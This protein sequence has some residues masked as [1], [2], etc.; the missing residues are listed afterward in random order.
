MSEV[1]E[2]E[3]HEPV[4]CPTF[5]CGIVDVTELIFPAVMD[6]AV[7]FIL[8]RVEH[9]HAHAHDTS[10]G[11][12]TLSTPHSDGVFAGRRRTISAPAHRVGMG[13]EDVPIA[14]DD[15]HMEVAKLSSSED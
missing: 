1:D 14:D 13:G 5:S 6:A 9:V 10:S 15:A 11:I 4:L 3:N 7:D 12:S 2:G 8:G